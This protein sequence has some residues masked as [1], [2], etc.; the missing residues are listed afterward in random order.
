MFTMLGAI[1]EFERDLINERT[2][3]GRGRERAKRQGKHMGRP[4]QAAKDIKRAIQLFND[5]ETIGMS[6]SDIQQLT[7]VPRSTKYAE[8]R[9][10]KD[11]E[12]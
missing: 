9:K 8:I 4:A 10:L 3:E 5:R 6:V 1:A 7:G 12:E 11:K 2:S